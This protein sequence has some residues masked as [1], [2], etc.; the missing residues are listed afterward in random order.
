MRLLPNIG[1]LDSTFPL[2]R[3]PRLR[4]VARGEGVPIARDDTV[5]E[6]EATNLAP[7]PVGVSSIHVGYR[8]TNALSEAAVGKRAP[9][10]PLHELSGGPSFPATLDPGESVVWT[11]NL[12]QL[13]AEARRT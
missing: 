2:F 12:E 7:R 5:L 11:A 4:V 1:P 9:E 10:L 3:T 8:Y 6:I 13:T